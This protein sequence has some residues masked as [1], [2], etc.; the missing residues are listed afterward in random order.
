MRADLG[1]IYDDTVTIVNRIDARDA[2]AMQDVY[3]KHVLRSCM[4]VAQS[5]RTVQSDGTV[6]IGTVHKVQVPESADYVPYREFAK[7]AD[8]SGA[9]TVSQGDYIIRGEVAED[10]DAST[11]KSV[12]ASYEP[13]AFQVQHFRD[14]TKGAGFEHGT[15]GIMRFAECYYIEG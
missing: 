8:R 14:S 2:G 6:A 5:Q 4:W 9:F 15:V 3:S 10:I 11:L 1:T 7:M 12:V 13:D